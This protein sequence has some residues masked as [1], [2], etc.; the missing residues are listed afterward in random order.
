MAM[1][2]PLWISAAAALVTEA[3]IRLVAPVWSFGPKGDGFTSFLQSLWANETELRHS[4]ASADPA[5]T[6]TLCIMGP[7]PFGDGRGDASGTRGGSYG[8]AVA[9]VKQ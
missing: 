2:V 6:T 1:T 7:T 4:K 3:V 8:R 9:P 5:A